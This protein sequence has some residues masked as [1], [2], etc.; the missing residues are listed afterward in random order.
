MFELGFVETTQENQPG[1][2]LLP[3]REAILGGSGLLQ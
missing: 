2:N 3:A 1:Y